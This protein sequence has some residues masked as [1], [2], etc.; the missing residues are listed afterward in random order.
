MMRVVK[1]TVAAA[2]SLLRLLDQI[3]GCRVWQEELSAKLVH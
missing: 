1:I 3:G 2:V